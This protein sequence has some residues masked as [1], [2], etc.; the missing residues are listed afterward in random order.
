MHLQRSCRVCER[1]VRRRRGARVP[2]LGPAAAAA[3]LA[4]HLDAVGLVR[5]QLGPHSLPCP[6]IAR[7]DAALPVL[8][9]RN[10]NARAAGGKEL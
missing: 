6:P 7:H 4:V 10:A 2:R 9:P 3:T 5:P 8:Q 1:A